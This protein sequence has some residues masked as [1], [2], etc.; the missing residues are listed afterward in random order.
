VTRPGD[1]LRAIAARILGRT[2]A[3]ERLIDPVIADL[4]HEYEEAIRRG[5]VWRSRSIRVA[6][7][8]AFWKVAG[9]AAL[10]ADRRLGRATAIALSAG[11]IITA[12]LIWVVLANFPG[13]IESGPVAWLALHLVPQALTISVPVGLAV[14][15]FCRLRGRRIA[16]VARRSVLVLALGSSLI[17]FANVGWIMP[18]A[19]HMF[20]VRLFDWPALRGPNELPIGELRRRV[21]RS[22]PVELPEALPLAFWYQAR[23]ALVAAPPMLCLFVLVSA[24]PRR[25]R[26]GAIVP[27]TLTFFVACYAL[28][29]PSQVAGL[30]RLLPASAIAWIPDTV[31]G[32]A[33]IAIQLTRTR[34]T[35][36]TAE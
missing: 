19:N 13:R 32:L 34:A 28:F 9:L 27:V 26:S 12:L 18:A 1:R 15:V 17:T 22:L 24:A 23:L 10:S 33:T 5:D 21:N 4:Q 11:T 20:R 36:I 14:G 16:A 3:M 29:S 7:Y 31:V 35:E 6:G 30:T 8:I 2:S 25:G